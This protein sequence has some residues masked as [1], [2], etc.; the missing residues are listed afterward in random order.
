M[1]ELNQKSRFFDFRIKTH[2]EIYLLGRYFIG[3]RQRR[4]FRYS[5]EDGV[6][7]GYLINPRVLDA[8]TEITTDLLSKEGYFFEGE[9]EEGKDISETFTKKDFEKK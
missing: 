5:L 4:Y 1:L 7:D 6:K 9:D 8:R 2:K 3:Y